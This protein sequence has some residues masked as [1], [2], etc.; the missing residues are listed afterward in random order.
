MTTDEAFSDIRDRFPEVAQFEGIHF[1][2]ARGKSSLLVEQKRGDRFFYWL[3]VDD[4]FVLWK[5]T[6]KS[7]LSSLRTVGETLAAPRN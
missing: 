2:Y 4:R 6:T 7:C 1:K 3:L 5:V